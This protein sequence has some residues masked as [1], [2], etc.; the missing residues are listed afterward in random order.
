MLTKAIL[1]IDL[2]MMCAECPMFTW[3]SKDNY[4]DGFCTH[5]HKLVKFDLRPLDCPLKPIPSHMEL[6]STDTRSKAIKIDNSFR[7]GWN[8]CLG[9]ILGENK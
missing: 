6:E 4:S 5:S 3:A 7:M 1:I 2:P 8:M 9:E